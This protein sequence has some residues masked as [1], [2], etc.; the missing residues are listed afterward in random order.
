VVIDPP[1]KPVASYIPVGFSIIEMVAVLAILVILMTTGI[2]L[3][4]NTAIQARN[5]AT[6]TV[7]NLIEQARTRAITS[8][9][10][11]AL[12]IVDPVDLPN[13]DDRVRIGLFNIKEWTTTSAI[14]EGE[15]SNRW[16]SLNH[17]IIFVSGAA[18]ELVNPLD[19]PKIVIHY[20]GAKNLTVMAHII[21][22]NSRGGL[23]YPFGSASILLRLAQGRYHNGTAT[24]HRQG[25]T[26][27]ISENFLKIG[28]VTAR[29]YRI[30]G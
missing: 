6:E 17:G 9:S 20:G 1:T 27:T 13:A 22:F 7:I 29:P 30:S 16:Q 10:Y 11:V 28:R 26:K 25:R 14:L 3:V 23:H 5:T 24:P 8:K 18:S 2:S 19:P 12:A 4:N 21:A 15:L